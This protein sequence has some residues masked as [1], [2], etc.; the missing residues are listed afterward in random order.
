MDIPATATDPK[1]PIYP[2]EQQPS[3]EASCDQKNGIG[4]AA[5]DL[6][7]LSGYLAAAFFARNSAHRFLVASAIRSRPAALILRFFGAD[8]LAALTAAHRFRWPAAIR[9]RAAGLTTRF[10]GAP[11]AVG[12]IGLQRRPFH[13]ADC[14]SRR[15][16]LQFDRSGADTYVDWIIE[17]SGSELDNL[18]RAEVARIKVCMCRTTDHFRPPHCTRLVKSPRR[19]AF[20]RHSQPRNLSPRR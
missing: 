19:C 15:S 20:C 16:L 1:A 3:P 8:C 13:Q 18:S 5:N 9:F 11:V 12:T 4:V 10:T 2:A 17:I 6:V 14:G 7:R